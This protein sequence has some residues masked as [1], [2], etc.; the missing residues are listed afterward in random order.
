VSII[1]HR[2]LCDSSTLKISSFYVSLTRNYQITQRKIN[3]KS[4]LRYK[5]PW[6]ILHPHDRVLSMN[7]MSSSQVKSSR[8]TMQQRRVLIVIHFILQSVVIAQM[9][10]VVGEEK[11][12]WS[13]G[14]PC[15]QRRS[16]DCAILRCY[17]PLLTLLQ[18]VLTRRCGRGG[19]KRWRLG[20]VTGLHLFNIEVIF[21]CHKFLWPLCEKRN[22]VYSVH[23]VICNT[24]QAS[25][26]Y[27]HSS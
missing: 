12:V 15:R 16:S 13:E 14:N 17:Q 10:S 11:Y 23:G 6:R 24:T 2:S 27:C 9:L 19:S 21:H 4:T 7:L 5:D 3:K 8:Y 22:K 1:S 18:T 26:G 20:V 25:Q